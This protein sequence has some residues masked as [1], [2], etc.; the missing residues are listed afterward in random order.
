MGA[1]AITF[2]SGSTVR[3]FVKQ[4]KAL[5]LAEGAQ[6]PKTISIGPRTSK[7]MTESH[8]PLTR[9][10]KTS[11]LDGLIEAIVEELGE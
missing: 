2:T 8:V 1:H 6:I 10:A 4:A 11:S 9:E 5:Q 3:S 7:V